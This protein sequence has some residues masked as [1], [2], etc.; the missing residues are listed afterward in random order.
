M[1]CKEQGKRKVI[2]CREVPQLAD[3]RA[4]VSRLPR[5]QCFRLDVGRFRGINHR[6]LGAI[7]RPAKQLGFYQSFSACHGDLTATSAGLK[8]RSY[9]K[10]RLLLL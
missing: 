5:F 8:G 10:L 1:T 2:F 4:F 6:D 9:P 7:P 3:G